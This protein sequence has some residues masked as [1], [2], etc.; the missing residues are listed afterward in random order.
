MPGWNELRRIA[1]SAPARALIAGALYEA[2]GR[3]V[4]YGFCAAGMAVCIV[5]ALVLVRRSEHWRRPSAA[6]RVPLPTS[7]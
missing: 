4:A 6:E 3:G 1:G 2:F 5:A 7:H